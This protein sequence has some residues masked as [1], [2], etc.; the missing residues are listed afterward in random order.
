MDIVSLFGHHQQAMDETKVYKTP[1]HA[2][3]TGRRL[4][5]EDRIP[6]DLAK[7]PDGPVAE[8]KQIR[9][10][11]R[12]DSVLS[13]TSTDG[14]EIDG[15]SISTHVLNTVLGLPAVNMALK[16]SKSVTVAEPTPVEKPLPQPVD[17]D[18]GNS[19]PLAQNAA[20][21]R[22]SPASTRRAFW[23]TLSVVTTDEDGRVQWAPEMEEG[24][25]KLT[26]FTEKYFSSLPEPQ[27]CFYPTI[28]ITFVIHEDDDLDNY[29][30]PLLLTPFSY[31]TYRGS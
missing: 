2:A 28:D 16:L 22:K 23:Q 5:P 14:E 11:P 17:P 7:S 21:V 31:Q 18:T 19:L 9:T 20:P 13:M 12:S 29:H 30:V 1:R 8:F 24:T 4:G 15:I 26:F 25:Y 3:A 27:H 6:I 10:V